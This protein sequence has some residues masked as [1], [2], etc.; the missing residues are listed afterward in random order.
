MAILSTKVVLLRALELLA[1]KLYSDLQEIWTQ[2][3][4]CVRARYELR[5]YD[6]ADLYESFAARKL[7]SHEVTHYSLAFSPLLRVSLNHCI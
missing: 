4:Q 7:S 2:I 6:V 5:Q 3:D 1:D